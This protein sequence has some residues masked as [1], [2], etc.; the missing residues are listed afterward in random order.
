MEEEPKTYQP[1]WEEKKQ[2]EHHHHH[3]HHHHGYGSR[4][5]THTNSW[6]GWLKFR[7]KQAYYG[8]MLIIVVGIAFG[9][10]KLIKEYADELKAIP[11][12]D[13][14]QELK[15]DELGVKKVDE[16]E[17]LYFADSLK[18]K[19][20]LD[21][22]YTIKGEEHNVYRPPRKNDNETIDGRE[23]GQIKTNFRRWLRANG[24]DP[25]FIVGC[26]FLGIF[27]I[28]MII[29]AIIKIKRRHGL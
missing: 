1:K 25:K 27:L 19:L 13:P 21:T 7:D 16:A 14:S 9:A 26:V 24:G 17:A 8:L 4:P 6:G 3:H 20:N 12:G 15:V 28:G 10:Y 5:S 18:H 29:Y 23:W 11:K 22:V 2:E